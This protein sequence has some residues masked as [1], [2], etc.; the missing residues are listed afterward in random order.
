M[1]PS[2]RFKP[3]RW[4]DGSPSDSGP[5]P[6]RSQARACLWALLRR[7]G[8]RGIVCIVSGGGGEDLAALAALP[9]VDLARVCFG[10]RLRSPRMRPSRRSPSVHRVL[11][12]VRLGIHVRIWEGGKQPCIPIRRVVTYVTE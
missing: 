10:P 1:L 7:Q 6:M 4:N 9:A 11:L 3:P 2:T 8:F 12:V 5:Y